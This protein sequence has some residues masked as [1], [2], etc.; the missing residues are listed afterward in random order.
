M[1]RG[2]MKGAEG[3]NVADGFLVQRFVESDLI[4]K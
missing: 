4:E 1:R 3:M 2:L